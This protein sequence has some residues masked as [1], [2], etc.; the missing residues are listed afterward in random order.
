[1]VTDEGGY[2]QQTSKHEGEFDAVASEARVRR[3]ARAMLCRTPFDQ[4]FFDCC[5]RLS[6]IERRFAPTDAWLAGVVDGDGHV[7]AK[8]SRSVELGVTQVDWALLTAIQKI[9]GGSVRIA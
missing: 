5:V 1:M 6:Q 9:Y 4:E 7:C 2:R 8:R 3:V